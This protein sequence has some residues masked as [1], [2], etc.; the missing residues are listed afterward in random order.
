VP[1]DAGPTVAHEP[2]VPERPVRDGAAVEAESPGDSESLPQA[3]AGGPEGL[4]FAAFDR[5]ITDGIAAY[6]ATDGGLAVPMRGA[7]AVVVN[8][9][10]TLHVRGYGGYDAERLYLVASSSK[11][12]SAGVL[13][14]L[15]ERGELDLDAPIRKYLSAWGAS[16]VGDVSAAQ[17]LSN[18]S[19]LPALSEVTAALDNPF[20][21][22]L[23]QLCQ[24]L[25]MGTLK[26]CGE[27][28][29]GSTPPHAADTRFAY[30]GSAWQLAG[31]LAEVVANKPWAELLAETYAACGVRSLGYTNQFAKSARVYPGDFDGD[32]AK[33]ANTENPNI[34]GGAYI[35]A[36]DYARILQMHLAEGRCGSS[37]VLSAERVKRM[38][39]D[40]VSGYGGRV[41]SPSS[42]VYGDGYGFGWWINSVEGY[43]VD[44]GT[45]GAFAWLDERRGYA[46]VIITEAGHVAGGTLALAA[47]AELDAAIDATRP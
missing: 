14:R 41:V 15:A 38:R 8:R 24:F 44:P 46:A 23:L 36:T 42:I 34:E 21:A 32:V 33:L 20:N 10:R 12:L 47:K 30:G 45:Y 16:P 3:D 28:I 7:S 37:Q 22:Y 19:G 2:V 4:D 17:L 5:A 39:R 6:N 27:L 25:P 18:S 31:A 1:S 35:T 9:D 11:L 13:V 29:Y 26:G 40:R 43:V